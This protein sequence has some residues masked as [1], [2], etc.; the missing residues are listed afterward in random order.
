MADINKF[1]T[2][3]V[4]N[5]VL[6]DSSGDAVVGFSHT[7]QEALNAVLDTSNNRLNISIAGGTISGDVTISGDLTV[8]GSNTNGTYD[9]II[10]GALQITASSAFIDVTDTDSSLNVKIASGDSIGSIGTSTNHP[11]SIRTNNTERMQITSAGDVQI[12]GAT[13]TKPILTLEQTGNNSNAGQLIF[14]TSGAANDNDLSGVIR[15]KGMNDAG[16][17]EE[18]EY[19][20]IFVKHSDVSDGS[21]DATMH[22][23]TQSGGSLDSRMVIKSGLVGIGTSSPTSTT[24]LEVTGQ[25]GATTEV[26]RLNHGTYGT[27]ELAHGSPAYGGGKLGIHSSGD[28]AI[29]GA[30][31]TLNLGMGSTVIAVL[32]TDS[33]ISLSNNDG[34][35]S[36]TVFGK[37]AFTNSGT[38]LG[39]VGA[40]FNVA[41]GELAMGSGTT[42]DATNNVAVGYKA[43]EVLS[44]AD[45]SVFV[46]YHSGKEHG[47]GGNNTAIGASSMSQSGGGNNFENVFVGT[48]SGSGD[49]G[50]TCQNNTAIGANSMQGVINGA[51]HNTAIGYNTLAAV[52]SGDNNIALGNNAGAAI[53]G[54][55]QNILIGKNAGVKN[56]V[57]N[58]V[59]IGHQSMFEV[60]DGDKNVAIGSFAMQMTDN[61]SESSKE[62]I[63]IGYNSGAGTWGNAESNYNTAVGAWTMDAGLNASNNNTALGYQ[64]LTALTTGDNNIALG[65]G[66]AS[67]LTT[68]NSTI[69]IG[70]N[71]GATVTV[72]NSTNS[73]GTIGIGLN[74][75]NALTSGAGNTAIG[76]KAASQLTDNSHNTAV[77]YQAMY[78]AGDAVYFNTFIGSN[79][80]SGDWSGGAN[81]NTAVGA[82]TMTGVMTAAS[83][84]NVA[85][86]R[87]TL[88]ALTTGSH[89]TAVGKGAGLGLLAGHSNVIIGKEAYKLS[90][91]GHGVV[92]IGFEAL[93]SVGAS[94]A[95]D[96]QAVAIGYQ[97]GATV[98]GGL[99]N[100]LLGYKADVGTATDSY[101]TSIG[102]HG[103]IKYKTAR[104]SITKA[105]SGDNTVI[106]E[107]CK[108]PALSI[109][110][111]VT[112]TVITKSNL[113]TYLLNLSLSTSS[114]TA[115]DGALANASTT[116]T[117]PEILGAGGVAT[118]AQNSATA[119]GTAADIVASSGGANNTVYTSMPT[120]T[121]VGTADTFLYICNAGTGNGTTDSNTVVIDI[122]VEYQ[123]TD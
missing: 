45:N 69:F 114:G 81:S 1:T 43:G 109:I 67:A 37:T 80:G 66:A 95:S 47:G 73:D 24:V 7:T 99:N 41:I 77:G 116:I 71:A 74:A 29:G 68:A 84:N 83:I 112:A 93:K 33:R 38:V 97:A 50:G 59:A 76:Y 105:H 27:L 34:N 26:L 23:R 31:S 56:T 11:L 61:D 94:S 86:G 100:T 123:G 17:P 103:I 36:N 48:N 12:T 88:N 79:S 3:E 106:S 22:F 21:E 62:N 115:A 113:G 102:H 75:L 6:L 19:A 46:G 25:S 10:Q 63:F 55:S 16:T 42:T 58:N 54:A 78:Q 120:T 104:V 65:S 5:K 51:A 44:T 64:G 108:I 49:W 90:Q 121:I 35:T 91:N 101:Q 110:H 117:V 85:V 60:V 9:E 15:F 8:E 30:G 72:T 96:Q 118:Y 87:D 14:L 28:L 82:S 18:I 89:N 107:V 92:A 57:N 119:L 4:L 32:N 2:K 98:N 70:N 52:T 40:D 39:D 13:D 122:C 53:T 20:T 111:R